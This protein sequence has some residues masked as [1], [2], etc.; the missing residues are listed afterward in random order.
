MG[1]PANIQLSIEPGIVIVIFY[2]ILD[3]NRV[4]FQ[5]LPLLILI[6]KC[7]KAMIGFYAGGTLRIVILV[8]MFFACIGV[9]IAYA[10][11]LTRVQYRTDN[12]QRLWVAAV[13]SRPRPDCH[14]FPAADIQGAASF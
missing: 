8:A 1:L 6:F 3:L 11:F 5:L 12:D 2:N 7:F 14:L 13:S 9:L 4:L 10:H